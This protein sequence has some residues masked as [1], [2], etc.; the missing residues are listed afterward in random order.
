MGI[1]PPLSCV[2]ASVSG[3]SVRELQHWSLSANEVCRLTLDVLADHD[4]PHFHTMLL[5]L[6]EALPAGPRGAGVLT[7]QRGTAQRLASPV[8]FI[9]IVIIQFVHVDQPYT[10][11]Y[12]LCVFPLVGVCLLTEDYLE[13]GLFLRACMLLY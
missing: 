3:P 4:T 10:Q 13:V 9:D 6:L 1:G 5:H 12:Q 8:I 7:L 11:V 2:C